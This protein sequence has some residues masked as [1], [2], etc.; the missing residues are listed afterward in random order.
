M[1]SG[2]KP[3]DVSPVVALFLRPKQRNAPHAMLSHIAS[4]LSEQQPA[5]AEL[6]DRGSGRLWNMDPVPSRLEL[7]NAMHSKAAR[8]KGS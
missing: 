3:S 2:R 8:E 6:Y 5:A 4:Q 1:T 7:G